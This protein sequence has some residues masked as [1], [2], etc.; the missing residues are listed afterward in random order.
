VS[1]VFQI[2]TSAKTRVR[3]KNSKLSANEKNGNGALSGSSQKVFASKKKNNL[4]LNIF[5]ETK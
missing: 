3:K 5:T 1:K 2:T 4:T